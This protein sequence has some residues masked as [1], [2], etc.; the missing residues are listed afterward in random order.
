MTGG[1]GPDSVIDAVGMEAHGA[2]AA[3]AAQA[4]TSL[5]PDPVAEKI[6]K[7]AG[8]EPPARALHL[9]IDIVR[10]GGTISVTG[11]YGGMAEPMPMMDIVRQADPDADGTGKR[12]ALGDQIMPLLVGERP[13]RYRQFATHR[14][15][16]E[17][18]PQAYE[19]FQKK[20]DGAVKILLQPNGA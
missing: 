11:V 4:A 18:A 7:K 8:C 5:L 3:K 20:Q 12:Q 15:P 13:A 10:R 16:L 17:E 9:A 2:P 14:L 1:R 19:M 6:M